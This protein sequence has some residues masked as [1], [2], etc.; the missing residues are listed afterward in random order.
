MSDQ[1]KPKD[2]AETPAEDA[3]KPEAKATEEKPAAADDSK[4]AAEDAKAEKPKAEKPAEADQGDKSAAKDDAAAPKADGD[5]APEA[6]KTGGPGG[7]GGG[8]G[9]RGGGNR[10]GR[11]SGPRTFRRMDVPD[12]NEEA[13]EFLEK[14][15]FINRCSKV[16][17]GGRRFSF[18]ALV[19]SGDMKGKGGYGFG[20][21]NEVAECIRKATE[22]AK[23]SM[24][25]VSIV[26]GTIPHEV[27]GVHGGGRVLLR[28]ASPGTGI[29][30]GGAVRAVLEAAG[31]KDILT[32]SLG[33]KNHGNVV[34]ATL[35]G[36]LQLRTR[37][38]VYKLR[39]KKTSEQKAI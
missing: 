14:V 35:E 23:R 26:E 6:A 28:P 39:G 8:Y 7:G 19:V 31:V 32:K 21:A 22:I 3:P 15:V 12:P 36:L 18:S 37:D 13:P 29:I 2:A 27:L 25:K 16:V 34:K 30:A 33:S 20:K 17:K 1:E 11:N 9:N 10:G 4:P 38:D 5:K 24:V